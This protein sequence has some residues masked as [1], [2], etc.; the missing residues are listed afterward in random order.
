MAGFRLL[1]DEHM[2]SNFI[3][4]VDETETPED[5]EQ[6]VITY[7]IT[8]YPTDLT[9]KGY[10]D[11]WD[12]EQLYLPPFQRNY[13]WDQ[14][15]A[16]KLIES[17][18]IGLPVPGVFLYK[19]RKTNRL[20]I[21]DGQQRILTTIRY[22][23]N[24]FDG[25]P[26]QLKSVQKKWD[27]KRFKDLSEAE[28]YLLQ[29]TVLRATIVQQVDPQD[30]SSI[31][32]IYERLNTGGIKLMPMEIR[33]CVYFSKFYQLLE[34]L[35]KNSA[36][37]KLID[38]PNFDKRYRDIEFILRILALYEN[39][40]D[41]K[42]PMKKFLNDYMQEKKNLPDEIINSQMDK[43]GTTFNQT[44]DFVLNN[45]GEKPFHIRGPLNY[46]VMDST[47]C[48]AMRAYK[49]KISNFSQRFESLKKD[50]D[51]IENV[52]QNTSDEKTL[53]KRF[54]LAIRYLTQ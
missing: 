30:D 36:W 23:T 11:K 52:T 46:A 1:G 33:K 38:Q 47:M 22:F 25:K 3:W 54:N 32:H 42:K 51:Y 14:V 48:T 50:E 7:Q 18:L 5:E 20:Q 2:D 43:L 26:F 37:R 39:F 8:Y 13:V 15:Q 45:L 28:R 40:N 31:Y 29:D 16:S 17:F 27:G 24:D 21:I 6:D 41:Y 4:K 19:E 35:N 44:C 49:E 12:S 53:Q 9:L 10:L 34:D